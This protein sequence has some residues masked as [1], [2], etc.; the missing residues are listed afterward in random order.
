MKKQTKRLSLR[1]ETIAS[2]QGIHGGT[3]SAT[4]VG[5]ISTFIPSFFDDNGGPGTGGYHDT[6]YRTE[7]VEFHNTVI[8]V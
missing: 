4:C 8:V 6:V 3:I 7:P 5:M 1:K 2:L